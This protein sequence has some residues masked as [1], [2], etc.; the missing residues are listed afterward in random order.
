MSFRPTPP[1]LFDE[2]DAGRITREQLHAGLSWHA[3]GLVEEIVEAHEDPVTNWWEAMLAKRAAARIT[4][5][6]GT[7]RIRH[8]LAALSRLPDFEPSRY[9]WNAL[10]PDVP[11][12]CFFRMRRE[13][14]F[15]LLK[16]ENRN[17]LIRALIEHGPVDGKLVRETYV[18][19]H[20]RDGLVAHPSPLEV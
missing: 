13:P 6:H 15:R 3:E 18:L 14:L 12:H 5:R 17:G 4:S 7:W 8:V 10:H 11:L 16:L 9:L 1:Q 20:G 19:E 2:F